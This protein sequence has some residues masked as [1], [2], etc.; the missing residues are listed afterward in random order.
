MEQKKDDEGWKRRVEYT[1]RCIVM[2]CI[3]S[4]LKRR[5]GEHLS[6]RREDRRKKE[7][8]LKTILWKTTIYHN[9]E[10]KEEN[11]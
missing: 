9:E 1:I 4:R 6:S 7:A 10:N 2:E 11:K 3:F 8:W 5:Q